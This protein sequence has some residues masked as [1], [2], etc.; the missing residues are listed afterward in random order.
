[1]ALRFDDDN[2]M[3]LGYSEPLNLTP[4]PG[5]RSAD[6][7][8][9]RYQASGEETRKIPFGEAPKRQLGR[10]SLLA[11]ADILRLSGHGSKADVDPG[12]SSQSIH[13]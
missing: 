1:M 11:H 12:R 6:G 13:H 10:P 8:S 9:G 4:D 3:R 5:E 7:T 2:G